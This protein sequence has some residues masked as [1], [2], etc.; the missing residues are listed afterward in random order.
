MRP[1]AN[2]LHLWRFI[3]HPARFASLIPSSPALSRLVA[4]QVRRS[5]DQYVV[6]LG[7]GTGVVTHALLA[8]GIPAARLIAVEVDP[9]MAGF[10]RAAYPEITVV[11]GDA[12]DLRR[13]LP[14]SV[15]GNV[16][17]VVC[18][19]PVSLLPEARQRALTD[20][21]FS[22]M[23][24]GGRLLVYSY[25]LASPLPAAAL[26]LVGRRLAWTLL[27]VPPASVW[28]YEAASGVPRDRD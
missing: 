8:S 2:R 28:G 15:A 10:L 18:G 4:G 14:P 26:G 5:G 24:A 21:A 3:R 19:I 12:L 7:A 20:L 13:A 23:P 17:T 22:L 27:N 25:R 16:G 11:E 1:T 9:R 6:E